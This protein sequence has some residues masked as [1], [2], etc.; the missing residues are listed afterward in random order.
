[1]MVAPGAGIGVTQIYPYGPIL[2]QH[3]AD[4]FEY[5]HEVLNVQL[6]G[7]LKA[8]YPEPAISP[9]ARGD[10]VVSKVPITNMEGT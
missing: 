8:E 5:L 4:L 7:G 10:L 2:S 6:Y 1:M 3:P 9:H